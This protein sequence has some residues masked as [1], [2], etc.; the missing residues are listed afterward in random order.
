MERDKG[1][2]DG[3]VKGSDKGKRIDCVWAVWLHWPNLKMEDRA[4]LEKIELEKGCQILL[5]WQN[6]WI[7]TD[8]SMLGGSVFETTDCFIAYIHRLFSQRAYEAIDSHRNV[9][10][11]SSCFFSPQTAQILDQWH[12]WPWRFMKQY[13]PVLGTSEHGDSP[14]GRVRQTWSNNNNVCI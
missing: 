12:W 10:G 13:S 5:L 8:P 3:Q 2:W 1:T 9:D 11:K 6:L 14:L 7:K 4:H